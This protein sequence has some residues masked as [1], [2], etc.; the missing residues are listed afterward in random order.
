M[1]VLFSLL[2]AKSLRA[3]IHAATDLEVKAG[4]VLVTEGDRDRDLFVI[5]RDAQSNTSLVSFTIDIRENELRRETSRFRQQLA[6][7]DLNIEQTAR[8]LY[9]QLLG[10]AD[11]RG[12]T[13]LVIV[14][15][16]PLWDVAFQA[17]LAIGYRQGPSK[18]YGGRFASERLCFAEEW[19]KGIKL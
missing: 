18:P 15:D 13:N 11:L 1:R 7:R 8:D 12:K 4:K 6:A 2:S 19:G 10:R 3:V 9:R 16:G 5:T 14:P 17:L